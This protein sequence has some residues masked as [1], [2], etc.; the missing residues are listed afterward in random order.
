MDSN[1]FAQALQAL[2]KTRMGGAA[3]GVVQNYKRANDEYKQN[4]NLA[5]APQTNEQARLQAMQSLGGGD[6]MPM[7]AVGKVGAVAA[8]GLS[9]GLAAQSP[10]FAPM[11]PEDMT[12][13]AKAIENFH[14]KSDDLSYYM[15][16]GKQDESVIRRLAEHYIGKDLLKKY[17]NDTQNIAQELLNRIRLDQNKE[18]INLR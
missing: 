10:K 14:F 6:V 2:G 13:A 15:N 17:G 5:M 9:R 12:D 8:K 1:I 4:L 11:H 16:Q 3:Q 7:G 18:L